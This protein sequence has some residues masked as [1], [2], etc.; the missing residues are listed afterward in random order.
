MPPDTAT[1]GPSGSAPTPAASA[2]TT[3]SI[4]QRLSTLV[5]SAQFLW[6][7]GHVTTV[8]Q[9]LSYIVLARFGYGGPKNYTKAFYGTLV[10]YGI[11]MYKAHGTPQ[12]SGAYLQHLLQDE[13][14][15][16]LLLAINWALSKPLLVTLLPYLVFSLFHSLNYFRSEIAPVV[17]PPAQFPAITPRIQRSIVWFVQSFQTRALR[18]VAY[19]EVFAIMPVLVF[20]IFLG[21]SSFM[22]P[23]LYSRFLVFRYNTSGLTKQ[24]FAELKARMDAAAAHPRV[25]PA[26][27]KV[28][29]VVQEKIAEMGEIPARAAAAASAGAQ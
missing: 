6:F 23:L 14:T 25:P 12:F 15:W 17:L 27:K 10:S 13:N 22:A 7:V 28:Y 16:Y 18:I 19:I 20:G 21:W 8:I 11:I 3:K 2:T 24:A 26:V 4:S 5:L 29:V 1:S 9:A